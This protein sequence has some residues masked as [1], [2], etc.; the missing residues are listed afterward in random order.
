MSVKIA[1]VGVGRMGANMARRLKDRHHD[2][3]AVHDTR[4]AVAPKIAAEL[5]D[6]DSAVLSRVTALSEILYTV[7]PADRSARAI[8]ET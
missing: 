6:E 2:I 1:I 4:T 3:V 5:G 7:V 8:F